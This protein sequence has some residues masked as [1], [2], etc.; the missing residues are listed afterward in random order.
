MKL[1]ILGS[2]TEEGSLILQCTLSSTNSLSRQWF[3]LPE[4]GES[5]IMLE[6]ET[7]E[8][9]VIKGAGRY[10]CEVTDGDVASDDSIDFSVEGKGTFV[11][12]SL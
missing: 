5:E 2:T 1:T 10:R 7:S 8:V 4:S 3:F 11:Y 12:I 9:L 6:Q